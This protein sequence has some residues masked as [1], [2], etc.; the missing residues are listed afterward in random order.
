MTLTMAKLIAEGKYQNGFAN[1]RPPGHH[2]GPADPNGYCFFNNVAIA[3]QY[4]LNVNLAERVLIIDYD[5]HHGQGTQRVFYN[6][7]K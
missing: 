5:V 4:L 6:T 1:V 2:A 7:D 3:A